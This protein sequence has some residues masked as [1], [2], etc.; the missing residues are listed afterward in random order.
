[1]INA[2]YMVKPEEISILAS[3]LQKYTDSYTVEFELF[4]ITCP[5]C[6]TKTSRIPLDIN[7]LVFLK[8]QRLMSTEIDINNISVL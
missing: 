6:G 4:D 7:S 5:H 2:L 8:Y 1:M 3:L